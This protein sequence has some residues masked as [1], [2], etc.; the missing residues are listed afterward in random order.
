MGAGAVRVAY[1]RKGG[2]LD[3]RHVLAE[4]V[5][6]GARLHRHRAYTEE[7]AA[8][9]AQRRMRTPDREAVA[10]QHGLGAGSRPPWWSLERRPC[11]TMYEQAGVAPIC[12]AQL[13]R[14]MR[15]AASGDEALGREVDDAAAD[16]AA[17]AAADAAAA[18][19]PAST[20]NAA[21][22]AAAAP[23]PPHGGRAFASV[24]SAAPSAPPAPSLGARLARE[25]A[26]NSDL[27]AEV[28]N[29]FDPPAVASFSRPPSS[30]SIG[31]SGP[32]PLRPARAAAARAF[33]K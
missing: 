31:S 4:E 8:L 32:C 22:A 12:D 14:R 29:P 23:P 1:L 17:G 30:V 21:P 10:A 33:G 27:E 7:V 19:G 15:E 9:A 11:P 13:A 5:R 28:P 3:V 18:T 2:G 6:D 26:V 24:S 20:H 25:G 16:V